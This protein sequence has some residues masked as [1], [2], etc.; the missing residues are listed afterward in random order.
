VSTG[1][2]ARAGMGERVL[3]AVLRLD[4][5]WRECLAP[6]AGRTLLVEV[7]PR[8]PGIAAHFAPDRVALRVPGTLPAD[9]SVR[10]PLPVLLAAARGDGLPS[11]LH[12]AG[13]LGV[14]Q[15]VRRQL[16]RIDID[17][18][19]LLA[20]RLGDVAGRQS[21]RALRSGVALGAR[22]GSTIVRDVVEYLS[23]EA[24]VLTPGWPVERFCD[25]ID[26]LRD[27]VDRLAA[28]VDRLVDTG[29]EEGR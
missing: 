7:E 25:D 10:G 16:G 11:G 4:P 27:D 22:V 18:E 1:T 5:E 6:L 17:W 21:A 12:V 20:R 24:G 26:R 29:A 9:V 2:R 19:E 3:N 28:R 8:G 14:L 13:D 15:L 23:E